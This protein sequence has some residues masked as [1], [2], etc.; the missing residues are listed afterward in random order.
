MASNIKLGVNIDH[1]AT[2]RE[3][4][5]GLWPDVIAAAKVCEMAG[6]HQ[7]TVHLPLAAPIH[8]LGQLCR[9]VGAAGRTQR[10][11]AHAVQ[12]QRTV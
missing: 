4:R 3:A 1:V 9:P 8:L 12:H 7:I 11:V 10:R 5:I 6:A 2:L